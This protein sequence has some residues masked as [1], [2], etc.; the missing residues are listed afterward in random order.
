MV[1]GAHRRRLPAIPS[2]VF[3]ESFVHDALDGR[4]VG[5]TCPANLNVDHR[6]GDIASQYRSS[7]D[8]NDL[9][10]IARIHNWRAPMDLDLRFHQILIHSLQSRRL[11]NFYRTLLV[12]PRI[13]LTRL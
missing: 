10:T 2:N 13:S 12:E 3:A 1:V 4:H 7:T 9:Y 8:M 11:R 5:W 6:D